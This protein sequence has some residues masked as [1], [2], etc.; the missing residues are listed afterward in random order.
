MIARHLH[1]PVL[2]PGRSKRPTALASAAP[3]GPPQRS[4]A[5][6]A[7]DGKRRNPIA[8]SATTGAIGLATPPSVA[9]GRRA[10]RVLRGAC[11]RVRAGREPAERRKQDH[12]LSNCASVYPRAILTCARAPLPSIDRPAAPVIWPSREIASWRWAPGPATELRM[13]RAQRREAAPPAQRL[14][15]RGRAVLRQSAHKASVGRCATHAGR[16]GRRPDALPGLRAE[17][18]RRRSD[19][20]RA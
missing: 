17:A 15:A 5:A 13:G 6:T 12:R 1:L 9:P 11:D 16:H 10:R 19:L 2:P 7:D 14:G 8:R 4:T 20:L 3:I 18:G